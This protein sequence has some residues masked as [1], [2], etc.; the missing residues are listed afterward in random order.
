MRTDV[1]LRRLDEAL[2]R[3]LSE[4]AV[5]DAD[6]SEVMPPVDGPEGWTRERRAAF[7][8]F[9][10][11]RSLAAEPVETTCAVLVGTAVAGAARLCPVEDAPHAVEAG[12]WIGRSHRGTGVG[13]AVFGLLLDLARD[14]GFT[15]LYVRTGPDNTAVHR[16]LAARGAGPVR[17][18]GEFTA[19]IGLAAPVEG[20][21]PA[22]ARQRP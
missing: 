18:G 21:G 6:P 5:A 4:A 13:T 8:R 15:S 17:T 11:G 1:V 16:L 7:V 2:L 10:R 19:W 3:R 22:S 14:E 20:G 9:H 12:V